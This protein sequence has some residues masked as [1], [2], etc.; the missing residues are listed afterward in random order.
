MVFVALGCKKLGRYIDAGIRALARGRGGDWRRMR[1][2]YSDVVYRRHSKAFYGV[3]P[4]LPDEPG[5][6]K[7]G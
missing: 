5:R 2:G 3:T 6:G 4:G 1:D 7:S